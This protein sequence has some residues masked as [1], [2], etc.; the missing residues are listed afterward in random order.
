MSDL[1]QRLQR[2]SPQQRAQLAAQIQ[3]QISGPINTRL[4]AF[5]VPGSGKA[6]D[7]SVVRDDLMTRLP[8]YMVPSLILPYGAEPHFAIGLVTLDSQRKS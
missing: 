2:L 3:P 5:V 1:I 8:D 7:P 6:I 4:V